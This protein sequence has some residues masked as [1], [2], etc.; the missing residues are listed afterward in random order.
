MT[1]NR[2]AEVRSFAP[3]PKHLARRFTP[4]GSKSGAL[5][6][7]PD[8]VW[9]Y[10]VRAATDKGGRHEDGWAIGG[11]TSGSRHC[12]HSRNAVVY[13][14]TRPGGD[15]VDRVPSA[16]AGTID[17]HA[18]RWCDGGRP[19]CWFGPPERSG[20]TDRHGSGAWRCASRCEPCCV[21]HHQR[22]G[23][24]RHRRVRASVWGRPCPRRLR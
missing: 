3:P 13:R 9:A 15:I 23:S 14:C 8:P 17:R 4:R 7:A 19:G 12:G 10:T 18:A 6:R 1:P 2:I 16:L 22:R 11:P 21:A 5:P 20:S 24:G